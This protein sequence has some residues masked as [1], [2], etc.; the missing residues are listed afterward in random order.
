[1]ATATKQRVP[2]LEFGDKLTREEFMRRWEANPEIKHA[3]LIGGRVCMPH[4]VTA[5]HV[6]M[7][8]D[9]SAWIEEYSAATPGTR[10]SSRATTFVLSDTLQP[11][12]LLRVQAEYGGMTWDEGEYLAGAPE[13]VLCH[14]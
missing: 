9:V 8:A 10:G 12:M 6:K 4:L 14:G 7:H 3:E 11:D 1:M 2:P 13:L 5:E